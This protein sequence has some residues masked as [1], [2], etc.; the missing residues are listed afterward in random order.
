MHRAIVGLQHTLTIYLKC[1]PEEVLPR[2][3]G[4][5]MKALSRAQK[6]YAAFTNVLARDPVW[7]NRVFI[8]EA[9]EGTPEEVHAKVWAALQTNNWFRR[10]CL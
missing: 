4:D 10:M 1:R 8:V 9:G 2:L 7:A 3:K 5:K 6:E